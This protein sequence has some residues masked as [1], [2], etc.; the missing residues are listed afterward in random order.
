MSVRV[1]DF[2]KTSQGK[3]VRLFTL[4]NS[5]GLRARVITYGATLVGLDVPDRHGKAGDVTLGFDDLPGW[6]GNRSYFGA[7]IGRFGNRIARGRFTLDGKIYTLA[8]NDGA[9]HLHGGT[10]G[11]DKVIWDA[12]PIAAANAVK[13]IYF[14]RDGEE[15]YP[16][17]LA[18]SVTYT[19]TDANELRLDYEAASDAPTVVNLTHH[20]Y[21][22][23]ADA[24]RSSILDHKLMLSADYYLPVGAD[25]IPTGQLAPVLGTAMDFTTPQTIGSRIALAK[26]GYDHNWVLRGAGSEIRPAARLEDPASGRVMDVFTTEPGMQ[27]YSGNFLNDT[28]R[29]KSGTIYARHHGLCLEAQHY[30]DSPNQPTFPPVVLR[31]GETYRQTTI[32]H[33]STR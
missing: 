27:F 20:T 23:L 12:E 32:H 30:P 24:G 21:W 3:T 14:S 28:I 33:F 2:G 1:S 16:G 29:G 26:G 6:M 4:T 8:A 9:N 7:T 31:G 25:L 11:F 5:G 15:G 22:N 17:N 13:F 19:L 10:L 18:V